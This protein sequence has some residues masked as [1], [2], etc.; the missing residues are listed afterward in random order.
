MAVAAPRRR[1]QSQAA[2]APSRTAPPEPKKRPRDRPRPGGSGRSAAPTTK[3]ARKPAAPKRKAAPARKAGATRTATAAPA[4]RKAAPK[5]RS[6]AGVIPIAAGH[7]GRAAVAVTQLPESGLIHRLTRGRAWIGVLGVL[8][9][10]IVALNVV[11][12]SFAASAGKVDERNTQLSEE[13]SA[14]QSRMAQKYGQAKLRHE[15]AQLGL[16]SQAATEAQIVQARPTDV[17]EA[18]ARLA[19]AA[20]GTAA[21]SGEASESEAAAGGEEAGSEA[22]ASG[23]ETASGGAATG[24]TPSEAEIAAM[25]QAEK[26][27]LY[28]ETLANEAEVAA[29][30]GS[31]ETLTETPAG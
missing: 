29:T 9:V 21:A 16:S 19:A 26:N 7:A 8:L 4:R 1:S 3:P 6:P 10:G 31:P 23:E 28:E 2:P 22:A 27:A 17:A 11:T 24:E 18:A 20:A 30:E 5:R 12:L 13:N 14:L 15:A 25:S